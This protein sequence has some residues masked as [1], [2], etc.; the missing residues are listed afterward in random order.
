MGFVF[1]RLEKGK[2][3]QKTIQTFESKNKIA[4]NHPLTHVKLF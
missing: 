2:K 1:E 3:S 4:L